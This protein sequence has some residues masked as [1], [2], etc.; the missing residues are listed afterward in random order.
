MLRTADEYLSG[1]E[2]GREVYFQGKRVD[3]VTRHPELGIAARHAALE[4][5]LAED[6]AHRA[7]AV[8]ESDRGLSSYYFHLPNS[9]G[10][11]SRRSR[12]I[13]MATAAGGTLVLLVKEIG[14]DAVFALT[15]VL[16][17]QQRDAELLSRVKAFHERCREHD[18][19]LAVAQTDVKGS[20]R[21][22]P[23]QQSDPDLYVRVVGRREDGVI[24]RG[25]KVHTSCAP[26]V[27]RIIVLP[28]RSM[29]DGDE[30]WSLAFSVPADAPNLR[31]YASDFLA[32][33]TGA[34][35]HP[36]S[37][38]HRMVEALTVFDDVFVPWED[39]FF[40]D[41]PDL[42]GQ[43]ALGFVEYHRFTAVSYKLPLL[44]A[45]VGAG[46]AIARA[47]GVE[48]AAHVRDK[49]TW[50]IGYAESVRGLCELAALRGREERDMVYPDIL[51]TNLAKWVFARDFHG[52]LE[53]LQDLA[54][55]LLVTGPG[56]MDWQSAAV[57][58]VLEK[59]LGAA[60]PAEE[61]LG[62][63]NLISELT[64]RAYGGYQAVL[65][66]HAEGSVEAE[67]LAL[68]RS[69]KSDYAVEYAVKLASGAYGAVEGLCGGGGDA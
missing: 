48:K 12:L 9:A 58:P 59:Y 15:R 35:V 44:D 19:A 62:V 66:S 52:A 18:W 10:D 2:D 11:L 49:L 24:V 4:F 3:S 30:P 53:R 46:I 21:L 50:L 69:Y 39:V 57:R 60:W 45:M 20:R 17:R 61:R 37:G 22:G 55:G 14:T 67:K 31:M 34:F 8:V 25:A 40:I 26:Y 28:G 64:T 43:T 23:S 7:L 16:G 56:D 65:A 54:G 36:I 33:D 63:M 68:W 5:R 6:P 42:A 1:L 51:T 41:R 38:K 32:G 27:D 13:E 47:N 29:R